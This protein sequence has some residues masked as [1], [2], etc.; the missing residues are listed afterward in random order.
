MGYTG[1]KQ[2]HLSNDDLSKFYQ[3]EYENLDLKENE[4]LILTDDN[5]NVIDYYVLKNMQL[6]KVKFPIIGNDF[7]GQMKPRNP[8]QY[9][10][11]DLLKN[12]NVPIKLLTGTFGSGKSMACI[13][14][15][16]EAVQKG[17]F[18]KLFLYEIMYRLKIQII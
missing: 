2:I 1:Y 15:A 13:T 10:A 16:L 11:L 7:T 18:E 8:Q 6:E 14:A 5:D 3:G 17:K 9:C 4:Y 12:E